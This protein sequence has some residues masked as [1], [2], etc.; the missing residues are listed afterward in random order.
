MQA[1]GVLANDGMFKPLHWFRQLPAPAGITL[2]EP[3]VARQINLFLSDPQARLPSF[4]RMGTSEYSFPVA[5]KT[6]TSQGYRDAW[7]VAYSNRYSVGVWV[8][9]SDAKPMRKLSG[10]ASAA[11]LAQRIME[12]LH[13]NT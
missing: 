4:P 6:G 11:P 8:G 10:S 5:V 13:K 3:N 7:T 12:N 1:Y 2:L 9:R